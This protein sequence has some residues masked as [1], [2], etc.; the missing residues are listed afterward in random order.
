MR[1][2]FNIVF[3]LSIV[4]IVGFAPSAFAQ[5]SVTVEVRTIAA[6]KDGHGYDLKLN[7]IKRKLEK[8]FGSKYQHFSEI[9][10]QS[11]RVGGKNES[12]VKLPNGSK[13][14][15]GYAGKA[16]KYLKLHLGIVGKMSSTL[17]VKRG[18]TL[19]HAGLRHKGGIL[20]LAITV[21]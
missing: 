3:A 14:T 18:K 2:A 15:V 11:I 12:S 1:Y 9:R 16:G 5:E 20:I 6:T 8:K 13:L 17:R 10:T 21:K 4:L 7:D 19:F